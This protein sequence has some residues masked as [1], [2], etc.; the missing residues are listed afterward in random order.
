[1]QT[2]KLDTYQQAPDEAVRTDASISSLLSVSAKLAIAE[3]EVVAFDT[4]APLEK[5]W[6]ALERDNLVSL[7]QGYD[8]CNA[9]VSAY[10]RPLAILRGSCDAETAFI[11]PIE[12][13]HSHG[14]RIARFIGAD[15][16]N[17]N[18]GLFSTRFL[19]GMDVLDSRRFA[20]SLRQALR[21]KADLLLLQ[22]IPLEW[23]GRRNPLGLLPTVQNQNHAYQ[24]PLLESFEATLKQL[25]A[26]S[27]RKKFRVQSKRLEAL[28]GFDYIDGGSPS[29]Q[30]AFLDRFFAQKAE[31][32]KAFGQ[33]D[34]FADAETRAFLHGLID[35]RNGDGFGLQ[36]H[37]LRLKGENEGHIAALSGI[38]RKGDH[39]ICQFSSI[40]ERLAAEASPGEFLYWQM[41]SGMHG[42]GVALFDFGLGDQ[43]YK[44]SWAPVETD[45]HDVVLP[46]SRI[47]S[48]A[49]LA[50]RAVTRS[51]A[52]IKARPG[53]YK[54]A[55]RLRAKFG[56]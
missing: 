51:K 32:F 2:Q 14:V 34:V 16:S 5:D 45:H 27:R 33:P 36:M 4:M 37:A 53:L 10:R 41:I 42:K 55:Q 6:R 12:I 11:L 1:M 3:L 47:G 31:R 8:W 24:L 44:R 46:I 23:R 28:G 38:S 13:E 18:T 17:I 43:I 35:V 26:K 7:H 39:V 56:S 54:F 20:E 30:H 52:Y 48:I 49:G 40:D 22:N 29:E 21:G 19:A 9:W 15:H 25:N 50:H